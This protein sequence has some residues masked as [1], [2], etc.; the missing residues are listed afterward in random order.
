MRKFDHKLGAVRGKHELAK[1]DRTTRRA[2]SKPF[3]P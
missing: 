1:Q 3:A 2:P